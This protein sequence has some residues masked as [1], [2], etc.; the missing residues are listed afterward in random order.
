MIGKRLI[1]EKPVPLGEVLEIMKE[2][3][4]GELDYMQRLA[5]DYSQKFS[6]ISAEKSKKLKDELVKLEKLRD[7]QIIAII[8]LMPETKEDLEVIFMKERAKV[9]EGDFK[10]ILEILEK[11]R[12]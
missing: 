7:S 10:T 2:E 5:Y 12:K 1:E 3:K 9:E 6:E 11:Y 8:D 4:K